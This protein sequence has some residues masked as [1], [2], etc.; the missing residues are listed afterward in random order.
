MSFKYLE[1]RL[2]L[3]FARLEDPTSPDDSSA[4]PVRGYARVYIWG[5]M[6]PNWVLSTGATQARWYTDEGN[7]KRWNV[8]WYSI[9][10]VSL[11]MNRC[12]R[13]LRKRRDRTIVNMTLFAIEN[14]WNFAG[15]IDEGTLLEA[16]G[17]KLVTWPIN[18][19]VPSAPGQTWRRSS[20]VHRHVSSQLKSCMRKYLR[21]E[22]KFLTH[23][24]F[25]SRTAHLLSSTTHSLSWYT[26]NATAKVDMQHW[27]K[28][29][30]AAWI[31]HEKKKQYSASIWE[32]GRILPF[33]PSLLPYF[34]DAFDN[35]CACM[36]IDK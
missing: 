11:Y 2:D 23:R 25:S 18:I 19:H 22:K 17:Q 29:R 27:K 3:P 5:I 26:C 31:G 32:E 24:A 1:W 8:R 28:H 36:H 33:L 20:R 21:R 15:E 9:S 14:N 35:C 12:F 7:E 4:N 10:R 30:I 34:D 6:S 13:T 16:G